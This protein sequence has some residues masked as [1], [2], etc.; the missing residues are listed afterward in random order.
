MRSSEDFSESDEPDGALFDNIY[1]LIFQLVFTSHQKVL[2]D[3][4]AKLGIKIEAS[5]RIF[6]DISNTY[7]VNIHSNIIQ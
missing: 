4:Y 5:K 3:V 1:D 6:N 2:L 7:P